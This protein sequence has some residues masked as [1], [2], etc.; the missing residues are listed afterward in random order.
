MLDNKKNTFFDKNEISP[1]SSNVGEEFFHDVYSNFENERKDIQVNF[2]VL[3]AIFVIL[4]IL[5]IFIFVVLFILVL[6][7]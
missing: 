7:H 2:K 4:I 1:K 3:I 5:I 6:S